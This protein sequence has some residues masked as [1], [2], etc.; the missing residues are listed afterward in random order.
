MYQVFV[1]QNNY[2]FSHTHDFLWLGHAYTNFMEKKTFN[3]ITS[4]VETKEKE[5]EVGP[6]QQSRITLRWLQTGSS[7]VT[8]NTS[9]A[10]WTLAKSGHCDTASLLDK[11]ASQKGE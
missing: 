7:A 8:P 10:A 6:G 4:W 11:V 3:F 9:N 1:A 2:I 5:T